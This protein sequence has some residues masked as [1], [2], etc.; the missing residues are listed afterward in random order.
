MIQLD[1]I[2]KRQTGRA[3]KALA[4]GQRVFILPTYNGKY[5]KLV[6]LTPGTPEYAAFRSGEY[7]RSY[8]WEVVADDRA[9]AK[10]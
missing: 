2:D 9:T 3:R 5:S 7:K 8:W 1:K 6:C 4:N 10:V